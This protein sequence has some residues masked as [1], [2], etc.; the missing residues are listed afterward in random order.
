MSNVAE[1]SEKSEELI[2]NEKEDIQSSEETEALPLKKKGGKKKNSKKKKSEELVKDDEKDDDDAISEKSEKE[3][4]DKNSEESL[5]KIKV[6][7]LKN[8]CKTAKLKNYSKLKK[9]E[10][11][12]MLLSK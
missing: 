8:M 5:R 10:L 6:P 7:D 1:M 4:D 12:S 3:D 9:A 11:I 2:F